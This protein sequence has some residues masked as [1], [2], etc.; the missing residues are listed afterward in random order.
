ML[1]Q[2][3]SR[4]AP[5]ISE[6]VPLSHAYA[7][8]LYFTLYPTAQFGCLRMAS[9]GNPC[10]RR[11]LRAPRAVCLTLLLI[12]S[13]LAVADGGERCPGKPHACC[14]CRWACRRLNLP[15]QA[16]TK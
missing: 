13:A 12:C 3:K 15:L 5:A 10:A 16:S 2:R 8:S 6:H 7:T 4:F 14:E 1:S 9:S 11:A